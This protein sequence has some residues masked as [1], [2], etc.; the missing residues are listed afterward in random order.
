MPKTLVIYSEL[1]ILCK[2]LCAVVSSMPKIFG[3]KPIAKHAFYVHILLSGLLCAYKC[4]DRHPR[5]KARSRS[6]SIFDHRLLALAFNIC[7]IG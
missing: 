2:L 7:S 5:A 4:F 3:A 6:N 1:W